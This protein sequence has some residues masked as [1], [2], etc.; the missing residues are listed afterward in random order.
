MVET[1]IGLEHQ[2]SGLSFIKVDHELIKIHQEFFPELTNKMRFNPD[3]NRVYAAFLIMTPLKAKGVL[4]PVLQNKILK[5][6][7]L[8]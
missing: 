1:P 3:A 8:A 5:R 2:S 7:K 4:T 6:F